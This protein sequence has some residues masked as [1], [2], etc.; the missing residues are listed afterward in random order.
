MSKVDKL[1]A[2]A[3]AMAAQQASPGTYEQCHSMWQ[4]AMRLAVGDPTAYHI[5]DNAQEIW[6]ND[7]KLRRL[8]IYVCR[9][10]WKG[11][12]DGRDETP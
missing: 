1:K 4:Q 7:P 10:Y 9:W 8:S 12:W 2:Y 3:I 6:S 5:W 11:L